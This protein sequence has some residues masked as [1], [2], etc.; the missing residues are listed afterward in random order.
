MDVDL[1]IGAEWRSHE[2]QQ[3]QN[4]NQGYIYNGSGPIE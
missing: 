4:Q 2:R 1:Y 3:D